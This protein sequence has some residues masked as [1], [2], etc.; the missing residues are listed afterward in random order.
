MHKIVRL[1]HPYATVGAALCFLGFL[2]Y[3]L[4]M[5]WRPP[6]EERVESRMVRDRRP[7]VARPWRAGGSS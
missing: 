5:L 2:A 3:L 7:R 6:A 1:E 4:Y